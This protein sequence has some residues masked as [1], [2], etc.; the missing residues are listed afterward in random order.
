MP[1]MRAQ[2]DLRRAA[3]FFDL[4]ACSLDTGG[5]RLWPSFFAEARPLALS[6]PSLF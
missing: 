4:P 6:P 3:D 1:S 2:N 5:F